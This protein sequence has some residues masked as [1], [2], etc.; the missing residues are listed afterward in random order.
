MECLPKEYATHIKYDRIE[1]CEECM[2]RYEAMT[3][4]IE[5][6]I[7]SIV[8]CTLNNDRMSV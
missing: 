6:Y 4:E 2:C 5:V 8:F 1:K 7:S 3:T